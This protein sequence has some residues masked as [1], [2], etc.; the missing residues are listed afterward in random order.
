MHAH[1]RI[2]LLL[3]SGGFNLKYPTVYGQIDPMSVK[4]CLCGSN[5][6][7]RAQ[8]EGL[9]SM[10]RLTRAHLWKCL[11]PRVPQNPHSIS[12]ISSCFEPSRPFCY[13]WWGCLLAPAS[14]GTQST[15]DVFELQTYPPSLLIQPGGT[16]GEN[17]RR[18]A[19][20]W[21]LHRR[22]AQIIFDSSC[23]HHTDWTVGDCESLLWGILTVLIPRDSI[24]SI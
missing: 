14:P 21:S 7:L 1:T 11:C 24:N 19:H 3:T 15:Q 4:F 22:S 13:C 18:C 2:V 12:R 9:F 17:N 16:R 23:T 20:A 10:L 8:V 5:T 6:I